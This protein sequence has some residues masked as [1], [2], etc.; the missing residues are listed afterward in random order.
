MNYILLLLLSLGS[1]ASMAN[2]GEELRIYQPQS[3]KSVYVRYLEHTQTPHLKEVRI[4][5]ARLPRLGKINPI[6]A[7]GRDLDRNGSIE[8]WFFLTDDGIKYF[9]V[10]E[11]TTTQAV[12]KVIRNHY[13]QNG[14][15]YA[16]SIM[17]G[18]L[19][20]LSFAVEKVYEAE[21]NA[22]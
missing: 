14:H 21:M 1:F 15:G 12:R 5:A 7:Y 20:F 10:E 9:H 6:I 11:R 18:V 19:G 2:T 4:E 13:E 8:S 17:G 16:Q 3:K 22:Y